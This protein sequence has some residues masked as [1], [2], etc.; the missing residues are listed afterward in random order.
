LPILSVLLNNI[1]PGLI[2]LSFLDVPINK[3]YPDLI[4]ARQSQELKLT[5]QYVGNKS[6]F[7]EQEDDFAEPQLSFTLLSGQHPPDFVS[8]SY[9]QHPGN[10]S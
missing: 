6:Y 1:K 3:D 8:L 10:F 4:I 9:L 2:L 5:H 7:A